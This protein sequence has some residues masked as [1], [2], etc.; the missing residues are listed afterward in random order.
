MSADFIDLLKLKVSYGAQG[1]DKLYY[2]DTEDI[3][4]YPYI[5]QY[6]V[7]ETNREFATAR[8]YKGNNNITWE[9][10]YNFNM[11]VDFS[12]FNQRLNG[13][14]EA[15]SRRTDDMLYYKTMPGYSGDTES[16]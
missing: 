15:F 4:Y 9:T 10:S 2:P 11:G 7:T 16:P 3:N 12:M 14:L 8:S 1:N 13:T 5:D 6:D